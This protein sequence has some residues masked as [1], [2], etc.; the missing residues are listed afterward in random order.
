MN[1]ASVILGAG[2]GGT[3]DARLLNNSDE[4]GVFRENGWNRRCISVEN[5]GKKLPGV[6]IQENLCYTSGENSFGS[7]G[8]L[9][10]GTLAWR[11]KQRN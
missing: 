3:N 2:V 8:L 6:F 10:G 11:R 4:A 9:K 5:T 1:P 7:C